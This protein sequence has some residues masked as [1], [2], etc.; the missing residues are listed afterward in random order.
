MTKEAH[1]KILELVYMPVTEND[2]VSKDQEQ[3]QK[4]INLSNEGS[5]F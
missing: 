3:Q 1:F 5:K 2:K 4:T